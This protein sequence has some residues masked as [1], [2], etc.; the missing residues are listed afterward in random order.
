[1]AKKKQQK[2]SKEDPILNA[3]KNIINSSNMSDHD[4]VVMMK[5]SA[6]S[7]RQA[8]NLSRSVR[9]PIRLP[10]EQ[11]SIRHT[12]ALGMAISEFLTNRTI[13]R[14]SKKNY[15]KILDI[16]PA[17]HCNIYSTVYEQALLE[18]PIIVQVV[19]DDMPIT[20]MFEFSAGFGLNNADPWNGHSIARYNLMKD[21][22]SEWYSIDSPISFML[23][24][25][26]PQKRNMV[27]LHAFLGYYW[28]LAGSN[29]MVF[30]EDP[31]HPGEYE[32]AV[33]EPELIPAWDTPL[34]ALSVG[35]SQTCG[36][37]S[38]VLMHEFLDEQID[39]SVSIDNVVLPVFEN[40]KDV[41]ESKDTLMNI[42][43]QNFRHWDQNRVVYQYTTDVSIACYRK[44]KEAL[45]PAIDTSLFAYAPSKCMV[46]SNT[47]NGNGYILIF[48]KQ[49]RDENEIVP[50]VYVFCQGFKGVGI[51]NLAFLAEHII[52]ETSDG[53]NI[54]SQSVQQKY[55]NEILPILYHVLLTMKNKQDK[56]QAKMPADSN[57]V[58]V[59]RSKNVGN[60][61]KEES[62]EFREGYS[63]PVNSTRVYDV[64][65]RT[66]RQTKYKEFVSRTGW[67]MCPH[68]RRG[69]VHRFWVGTGE[70]RH[71]EARQLDEIRVNCKDKNPQAVVHAIK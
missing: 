9:D 35:L 49:M 40:E 18:H 64:T 41:K 26:M 12:L 25:D 66:V 53:E 69:H 5:K 68:I 2:R 56:A 38:S 7:A 19:D 28:R 48:Y 1:M 33:P 4:F 27:K 30:I 6:A 11:K 58:S 31:K 21:F 10:E 50:G 13:Y 14:I 32:V 39:E 61:A 60:V 59:T 34:G 37:Y 51:C 45:N 52:I 63:L 44:Y 3:L 24:K 8:F 42:V 67:H 55:V 62:G 54:A 36:W 20:S 16:F 15:Q 70:N 43:Y 23:S 17:E 29:G 22:S 47:E 65:E 57:A 71:L 46:F